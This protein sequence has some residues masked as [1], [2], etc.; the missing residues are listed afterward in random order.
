M[1]LW[2]VA[3]L[4]SWAISAHAISDEELQ[5]IIFQQNLGQ[6]ISTNLA[7]RDETG[8]TVRLGDYLGQRPAILVMGYYGC[9]ML[10]TV[11][12]NGMIG[13]LQD[14]QWKMGRDY[15]V[16]NV[17]IDPH[18]TPALAA[19]KKQSYLLRYGHPE[20]SPG[21]HFL[22]GDEPNIR[23]L[24]DEVG[25]RYLWD[26]ET[27]QY[28]HPS[29]LVILSPQGIVTHYELGVV[30][31]D[32][33]L[34]RDLGD[35]AR[36]KTGS[37]VSSLWLLCFHYNPLTGKYSSIVMLVTRVVSLAVLGALIWL[38]AGAKGLRKHRGG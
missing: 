12:L 6:T 7:F 28:A 26:A 2:S 22:T 15:E 33:D 20:A 31:S 5:K 27:R 36:A 1:K 18:E 25:F 8:R 16:I 10:C 35:A 11:V 4:L 30:F 21:W 17:S 23:Q 3:L 9:P 34:E 24:A 37:P 13:T 19:A 38:V 32:A 29:G 14:I